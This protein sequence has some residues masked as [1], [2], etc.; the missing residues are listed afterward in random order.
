MPVKKSKKVAVV[1]RRQQVA[2]LYLQGWTQT[3]IAE[4][5]GV[6]QPLVCQDLKRICADWR[7]SSIRDF[8]MAREIELRR[9]DY[10]HTEAAEAWEK[11]KKPAQSAVVTGEGSADQKVRK[12]MKN[13]HGDPRFLAVMLKCGA[14]RRSLLG[15]DAPTQIAPVMPNGAEPYGLV[16]PHLSLD[17]LR[18]I[19]GLE[20]RSTPLL[21]GD[22]VDAV[23]ATGSQD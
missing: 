11:S 13:Q 12:T 8:D 23:D 18:W 22:V 6:S 2:E 5:L 21:V 19:K 4:H 15:L 20:A 14:D 1:Q 3:K 17:E 9:I 16:V 7:E 10:V